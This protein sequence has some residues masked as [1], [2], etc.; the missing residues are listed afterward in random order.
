LDVASKISNQ[1]FKRRALWAKVLLSVP[2]LRSTFEN[3]YT[4]NSYLFIYSVNPKTTHYNDNDDV[5]LRETPYDSN[6]Q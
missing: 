1:S 3:L 4:Q 6:Q 2:P 5:A